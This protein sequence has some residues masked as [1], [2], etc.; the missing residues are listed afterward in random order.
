MEIVFNSIDEIS[1]LEFVRYWQT[2]DGKDY[3]YLSEL[4]SLQILRVLPM[5]T[6]LHVTEV[7]SQRHRIAMKVGN[8]KAAKTINELFKIVLPLVENGNFP[9]DKF[10]LLLNRETTLECQNDGEVYLSSENVIFL[11][12]LLLRVFADNQYGAELLLEITNKPNLYH[13]L[14][15]PN[16]IVAS[17]NTLQ[18]MIDAT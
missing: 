6:R 15:Q 14:E 11:Q 4:S 7:N 18:E 2:T 3:F 1:D 16:K 9:C 8:I 5:D 17:Y 13:K 10:N 12:D